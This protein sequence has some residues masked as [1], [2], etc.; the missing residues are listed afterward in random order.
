MTMGV[1]HT[2]GIDFGTS[3]SASPG[4]SDGI[5]AGAGAGRASD[6]AADRRLLQRRRPQHALRPRR[7]R[8]V[9]AGVEGRLMRS[10]KSLLGSSLMQERTAIGWGE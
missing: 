8:D 5:G 7:G 2:L 10:L 1:S 6:H 3:N 9:P 4:R